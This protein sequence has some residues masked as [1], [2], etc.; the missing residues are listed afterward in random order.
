MSP[1]IG[2][3][4]KIT[5]KLK[6]MKIVQVEHIF[7]IYFE[8]VTL[9]KAIKMEKCIVFKD[10]LTSLITSLHG[11][12]CTRQACGCPLVYQKPMWEHVFWFLGVVSQVTLVGCEQLNH[13]VIR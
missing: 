2:M 12:V 11:S 4:E 10:T 5:A 9:E 6:V 7:T 13:S 8:V 1:Y 3:M